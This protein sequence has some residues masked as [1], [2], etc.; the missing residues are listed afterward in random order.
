MKII[1]YVSYSKEKKAIDNNTPID[2]SKELGY[3]NA[4]VRDIVSD[5]DKCEAIGQLGLYRCIE[6]T[7]HVYKQKN[8]TDMPYDCLKSDVI[9]HSNDKLLRLKDGFIRTKTGKIMAEK[10]HDEFVAELNYL[11]PTISE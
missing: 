7:Q 10:L 1:D 5:A 3:L 11:F 9:N 6:Y 2:F 4:T 8:Q